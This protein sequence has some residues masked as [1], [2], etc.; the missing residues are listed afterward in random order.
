MQDLKIIEEKENPLFNRKEISFEVQAKVVPSRLETMKSFSEKF[1][2]PE[3]NIKIK[4]IYG[5]FGTN[6][7]SG[8]VFIYKTEEDKNRV[9]IKKKK[10]VKKEAPKEEAKEETPKKE[11]TDNSQTANDDTP[12]DT[13]SSKELTT[14][15]NP[16]IKPVEEAKD[17]PEEV[18]E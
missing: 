6:V 13:E 8:S 1:S 5:R 10:D 11:D 18:K 17:K 15:E 14:Q 3:E 16:E 7:F 12:K 4:G 2:T 9:E